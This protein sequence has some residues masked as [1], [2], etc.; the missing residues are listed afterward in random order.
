LNALA[1]AVAAAALSLAAMSPARAA[2]ACRTVELV[3]LAPEGAPAR[4][5]MNGAKKPLRLAPAP[6]AASADLTQAYVNVTEGRPVL[7]VTLRPDAA[8]RVR[9]YTAAHVGEGVAVVVD[10]QPVQV[11]H[12]RDPVTGDGVLIG[13]FSRRYSERLA[14]GINARL[15]PCEAPARLGRG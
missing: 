8:R 12:I 1:V 9:N 2:P 7:N 6:I 13:G 5:A 11:F 14:A 15:P 4:V 10:G 3:A